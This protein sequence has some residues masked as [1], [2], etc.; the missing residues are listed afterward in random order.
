MTIMRFSCKERTFAIESI[1]FCDICWTE[2]ARD[3][4]YFVDKEGNFDRFKTAMEVAEDMHAEEE[5]ARE[6][7][8]RF[9]TL[10]R[11]RSQTRRMPP[12]SRIRAKPRS[13]SSAR[14]LS[15]C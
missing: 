12:R 8:E 1:P 9:C 5:A 4:P 2:I 11:P 6:D 10:S 15:A 7:A 14:S 3:R 13:T